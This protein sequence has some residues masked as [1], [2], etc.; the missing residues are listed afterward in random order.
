VAIPVVSTQASNKT[1][2]PVGTR[3]PT[4]ISN[5]I[6]NSVMIHDNKPQQQHMQPSNAPNQS[7]GTHNTTPLSIQTG[8]VT[9]TTINV[10]TLTPAQQQQ[11][12][13]QQQQ[14]QRLKVFNFVHN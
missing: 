8:G 10:T 4:Q 7:L 14:F 12:Q 5:V 1:T 6:T 11:Q 9:Q 13:Q 3:F 2:V